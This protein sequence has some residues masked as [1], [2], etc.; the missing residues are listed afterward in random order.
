MDNFETKNL[1]YW[2]ELFR[3]Q[4]GN[5]KR[6]REF[7]K[8]DCPIFGLEHGLSLA[9]RE[10]FKE[11]LCEHVKHCDTITGY[12]LSWI[13]Y[14]SEIGY[15]Y[16][17]SEYW[18]TFEGK[19]PGWSRVEDRHFIREC[20][21]KFHEDYAAAKPEGR[22]A[23]HFTII[24]WPIAHAILPIDLQREMA[25]TLYDIRHSVTSDILENPTWLGKLIHQNSFSGKQRFQ[26]ITE[27]Y[28]LIGQIASAL[29]AHGEIGGQNLI[30]DETL[31]RLVEDLEREQT[32]R[33]WMADVRRS[34]RR[35]RGS[36]V[37][38]REHHTGS[39]SE[40]RQK[41]TDSIDLEPRLILRPITDS[42]WE[43]FVE[44]PDI[45]AAIATRKELRESLI[46][47]R[48]RVVG[49]TASPKPGQ[50]LIWGGASYKLQRW[51]GTEPLL[52]LERS[53]VELD[54][55]LKSDFR[56]RPRK[57]RLFRIQ[58]NTLAYEI[59]TARVRPGE[60]YLVILEVSDK[61]S[62]FELKQV[63]LDCEGVIGF[64]LD[65]PDVI[66]GALSELLEKLDLSPAGIVYISPVGI[67]PSRWDGQTEVEW[68]TTDNPIVCIRADYDVEGFLLE[69]GR[70]QLPLKQER[71][72]ELKYVELGELGIGSHTLRVYVRESDGLTTEA[73]TINIRIREPRRW[74]RHSDSSAPLFVLVDPPSPTIEQFWSG[75]V[76]IDV[77]GPANRA[78][79]IDFSLLSR[80]NEILSQISNF[81]EKLVPPVRNHESRQWIEKYIVGDKD[82]Q[83]VYDVAESCR[84][85]ISAGEFGTSVIEAV[86]EYTPLR[87]SVLPAKAQQTFD[88]KVLDDTGEDNPANVEYYP[89]NTPTSVEQLSDIVDVIQGAAPGLYVCYQASFTA[90]LFVPREVKALSDL[91]LGEITFNEPA[92]IKNSH[93]LLADLVNRRIKLLALWDSAKL[94]GYER[95]TGHFKKAILSS[96]QEN[97]ND[98]LGVDEWLKRDQVDQLLPSQQFVVSGRIRNP[99]KRELFSRIEKDA[100]DLKNV[101][102]LDLAKKLGQYW[103]DILRWRG[104]PWWVPSFA[105]SILTRP[106]DLLR[107]DSQL[108]LRD[109]LEELSNGRLFSSSAQLIL[110]LRDRVSSEDLE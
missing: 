4:F 22:W 76:E 75:E 104:L 100:T 102:D 39:T 33:F 3:E 20:F 67:L 35:K 9:Q 106:I 74:R 92:V 91:R 58:K 105:I 1:D 88:I 103:V 26:H 16:S 47:S 64:R 95:V 72:G 71:P 2:E 96:I 97:I 44:F 11:C 59:K 82:V 49:S 25:K 46:R 89:L 94:A 48:F 41:H 57:V 63:E 108:S 110:L 18:Q 79:E 7:L 54:I 15:E 40:R 53:S 55:F 34:T 109:G 99:L 27:Q 101:S 28:L 43:V 73:E 32:A 37:V 29:L 5:L 87:W 8:S 69:I 66:S 12:S 36:G 68:L 70:N 77:Y 80:N 78:L 81:Q 38:A 51:P 31:E 30:D 6:K 13:V 83:K 90:A 21:R 10:K 23:D 107:T 84:L 60:S 19:T 17:G 52:S 24:S 62:D 98:S 14:T 93:S 61:P 50:Q 42:G 56:L 86:R 45:S 85:H 65:I